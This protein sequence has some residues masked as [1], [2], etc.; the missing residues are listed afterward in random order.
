MKQITNNYFYEF[1]NQQKKALSFL[2]DKEFGFMS[3]QYDPEVE[4]EWTYFEYEDGEQ[5]KVYLIT[6]GV[7][8]ETWKFRITKNGK[9]LAIEY[10]GHVFHNDDPDKFYGMTFTWGER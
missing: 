1:T 10:P 8:P 7:L 6:K 3:N 2:K 5:I 4:S 9:I